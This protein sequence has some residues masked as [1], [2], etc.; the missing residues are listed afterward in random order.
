MLCSDRHLTA[1]VVLL[2]QDVLGV[3]AFPKHRVRLATASLAVCEHG[4]VK[5]AD[6]LVDHVAYV[7]KDCALALLEEN[8]WELKLEMVRHVGDPEVLAVRGHNGVTTCFLLEHGPDPNGDVKLLLD[9]LAFH[10]GANGH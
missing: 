5:S 6:D 9:R 2:A 3:E 8:L 1:S 7:G 4:G 10:W